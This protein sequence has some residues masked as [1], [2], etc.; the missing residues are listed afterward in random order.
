MGQVGDTIQGLYGIIIG[1][2][3]LGSREGREDK[4][5]QAAVSLGLVQASREPGVIGLQCKERL[6]GK[7]R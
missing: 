2:K 3:D 7:S 6:L 4:A 1:L 5:G